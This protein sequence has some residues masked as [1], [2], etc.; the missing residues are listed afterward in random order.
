MKAP[1]NKSDGIK[2]NPHAGPPKGPKL[3]GQPAV[4]PP[5]KGQTSVN[6]KVIGSQTRGASPQRERERED[7]RGKECGPILVYL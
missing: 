1:E 3:V 7:E 2:G 6:V 5:G 4:V